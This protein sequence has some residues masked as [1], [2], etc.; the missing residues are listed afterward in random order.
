MFYEWR[1]DAE[2]EVLLERHRAI[3]NTVELVEKEPEFRWR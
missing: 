3:G 2:L 1:G